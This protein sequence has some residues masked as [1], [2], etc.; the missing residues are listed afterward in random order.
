MAFPC[1]NLRGAAAYMGFPCAE[2]VKSFSEPLWEFHVVLHGIP[3]CR[4]S[5]DCPLT[6]HSHTKNKE[7]LLK[8]YNDKEHLFKLIC[9]GSLLLEFIRS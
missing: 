4:D 8:A 6:W 3:M 9:S 5:T 1:R 7:Y 2:T